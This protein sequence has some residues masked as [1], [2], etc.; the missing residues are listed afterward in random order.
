MQITDRY[1]GLCVGGPWAGQ[2]RSAN[3]HTLQALVEPTGNS[4]APV[5]AEWSKEVPCNYHLT[6]YHNCV[7]ET[8]FQRPVHLW[9]HS[10]LGGV[11]KYDPQNADDVIE[12]LSHV[13]VNATVENRKR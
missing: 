6:T 10:S 9:V 12:I 13:Y 2:S 1:V 3:H 5:Y 11:L 7:V 4:H 8:G